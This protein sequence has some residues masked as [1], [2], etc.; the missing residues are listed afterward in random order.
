[1]KMDK[2][3]IEK[4]VSSINSLVAN[5]LKTNIL[6]NLKLIGAIT[7]KTKLYQYPQTGPDIKKA[8][9]AIMANLLVST[10]KD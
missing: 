10:L 1:M 3:N 4:I 8:Y 6:V 5:C 2:I 9:P 7:G